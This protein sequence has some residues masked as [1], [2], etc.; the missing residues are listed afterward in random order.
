VNKVA[1]VIVNFNMPERADALAEHIKA[2]TVCE[3]DI[4]LVDNGSDKVPPAKN[5]TIALKHNVQTTN[6][7]LTGLGYADALAAFRGQPYY[8]YWFLITSAEF[9]DDM[10]ILTPIVEFLHHNPSAVGI[11]PALTQ[12]STT[13][14]QH[15]IDRGKGEP[16]ETWF[17]DNIA[18]LYRADWFNRI[19]RFDHNLIYGWGIDL[20][21]CW[22]AREQGC[23]LWID[24][25][26]KV[27]KVTDIGY[28][29][30]RMNMKAE[31]RRVKAGSN[32]NNILSKR[33]GILWREMMY[34]ERGIE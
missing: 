26:V 24:E 9:I 22:K 13:S 8:T 33:Y 10:D 7:W 27:K 32:M 12:D 3:Y 1:V 31:E 11:H 14:W 16:R 17:I 30:N 29:M 2:H 20:E 15:M 19:G 28:S 18:S 34:G 4:I 23:T 5:T 6:G 21:T 25:R